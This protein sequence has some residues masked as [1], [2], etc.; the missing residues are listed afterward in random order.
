MTP[1]FFIVAFRAIS[2]VWHSEVHFHFDI[3]ATTFFVW[4]SESL[5]IFRLAFSATFSFRPPDPCFFCSAFRATLSSWCSESYLQFDVQS[6]TFS[7]VFRA[8]LSSWR[9]EPLFVFSSISKVIF[10]LAFRVVVHPQFGVQFHFFALTSKAI[11]F[12]I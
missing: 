6:H 9:S 12:S 2:L 11:T 7:S 5:F 10:C 3:R 4:R 1:S 8:A